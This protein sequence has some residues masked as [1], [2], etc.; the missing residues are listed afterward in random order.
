ML[1]FHSIATYSFIAWGGAYN[2]IINLLESL[3]KRKLKIILKDIEHNLLPRT[4]KE[5]FVYT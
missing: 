2:N 5:T 3:Q 4:L 1:F